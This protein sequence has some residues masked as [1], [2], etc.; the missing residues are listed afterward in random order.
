MRVNGDR[1]H[2][3]AIAL[4]AYT[5]DGVSKDIGADNRSIY[6]YVGKTGVYAYPGIGYEV[7]K[8]AEAFRVD[9]GNDS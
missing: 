2:E 8:F 7:L 3:I 1:I 5:I 6:Q 4:V 9:E